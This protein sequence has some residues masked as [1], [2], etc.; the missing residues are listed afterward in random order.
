MSNERRSRELRN[1][2][3]SSLGKVEKTAGFPVGP[4][5]RLF[6]IKVRGEHLTGFGQKFWLPHTLAPG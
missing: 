2:N 5:T 1:D 6:Y 4:P 3:L